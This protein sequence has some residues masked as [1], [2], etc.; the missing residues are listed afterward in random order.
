[1]RQT[2]KHLE[3]NRKM[4]CNYIKLLVQMYQ[5]ES[6]LSHSLPPSIRLSVSL[7]PWAS[8]GEYLHWADEIS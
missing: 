8:T 2:Q 3:A 5:R 4:K 6:D 1:M 7:S